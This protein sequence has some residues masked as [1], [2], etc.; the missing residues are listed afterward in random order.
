[1][2]LK[3]DTNGE[4]GRILKIAEDKGNIIDFVYYDKKF[5]TRKELDDFIIKCNFKEL[6]NDHRRLLFCYK[7]VFEYYSRY[8]KDEK[9]KTTEEAKNFWRK[10]SCNE[11]FEK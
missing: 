7:N 3:L 9:Y 11:K 1:M 4:V 6:P 10:L 2:N 8:R 5:N